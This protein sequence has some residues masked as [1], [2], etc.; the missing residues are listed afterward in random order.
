MKYTVKIP[1]NLLNDV[2]RV[3]ELMESQADLARARSVKP[4]MACRL[5]HQPTRE[6]RSLSECGLICETC[7]A[8]LRRKPWMDGAVYGKKALDPNGGG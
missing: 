3:K 6:A 4:V 8:G 5:C 7:F 1:G 2:M